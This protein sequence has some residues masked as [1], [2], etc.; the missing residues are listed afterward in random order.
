[1]ESLRQ[2]EA[3]LLRKRRIGEKLFDMDAYEHWGASRD[4]PE[5]REKMHA[6]DTRL[7]AAHEQVVSELTALAERV[8]KDEPAVFARWTELHIAY[9]R[10]VEGK[11]AAELVAKEERDAWAAVARGEKPFVEENVYYIKIDPVRYEAVFGFA[12]PRFVP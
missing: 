4:T 2:L 9:L 5:G 12:P 6:E 7:L 10:G 1:M 8:R 11:D 3:C